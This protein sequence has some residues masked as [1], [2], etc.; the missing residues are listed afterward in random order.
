MA[1]KGYPEAYEKGAVLTGL[2]DFNDEVVTF[3]A[4]TCKNELGEFVTAGGR[5]LLVGAKA[6]TLGKHKKKCIVS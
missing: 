2:A 3:H 4:G 5:V 1:A 6:E